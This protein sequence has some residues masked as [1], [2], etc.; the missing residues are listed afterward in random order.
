MIRL[1][2]FASCI[3]G[4]LILQTASITAQKVEIENGPLYIKDGRLGVGTTNPLAKFQITDSVDWHMRL[5]NPSI[6]G[7]NWYIGASGDNWNA[8]PGK[9][10]ISPA[11]NSA[12]SVFTINQSN[13]IGIKENNP[14]YP[15]HVG[16]KSFFE[17][18]VGIG[19]EPG[20]SG[21]P[22]GIN[23]DFAMGGG[24]DGY[25]SSSEAMLIRAQSDTWYLGARNSTTQANTSFY[26][27]L[28]GNGD[29]TFNITNDGK[30]GV[31]TAIPAAKL[32]VTKQNSATNEEHLRLG[33]YGSGDATIR[34][35]TGFFPFRQYM[36]GV[37]QSDG[38]KFKISTTTSIESIASG[39][40]ASF[41]PA[42]GLSLGTTNL[43]TGYDLA[44]DGKIIS[45]GVNIRLS[46]NW[47]DYV[48][49]KNYHLKSLEEVETYILKNQHLPNIPS[50]EEMKKEGLSVESSSILMMEKIEE[51]TLYLIDQQ[52][53]L[54]RQEQEIGNL[55]MQI[56]KLNFIE[57]K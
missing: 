26:I 4:L 8:G 13:F 19:E 36:M 12:F 15:F 57:I 1:L 46:Q 41:H 35:V 9:F 32:D 45:E 10:L 6:G 27:G 11:S 34:F 20:S 54:K 16:D 24:E 55:K 51:L 42:G 48:F 52:K 14:L 17:S 25:D 40:I 47:P 2:F 49:A 44:V 3:M 33:Q 21:Q 31:G 53:Q 22:L 38:N 29:G 18:S 39:N 37:D 5:H 43:P 28:E 7:E 50:A 23:G 30:V 56:E